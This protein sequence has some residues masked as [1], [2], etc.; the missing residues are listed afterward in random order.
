MKNALALGTFDGIHKGHMCVLNKALNSGRPP[1][2]VI[3]PRP[4]KSFFDSS[5]RCVILPDEK[6]ERL[7]KLGFKE[8]C[9]LDFMSVK[10]MAPTEFLDMLKTQFSCSLISCGFNYRFGKDAA[11]DVDFLKDYCNKNS[12]ELC[13][14]EPF[15]Q[16][17]EILSSTNIRMKLENGNIEFVNSV[18]K[19]PFGFSGKIIDGD[20]RGRTIGFPTINQVYPEILTDVKHGVYKSRVTVNGAEYI[21][22]TNIG[23][24]PTF[25]NGFVSAETH[26]LGFSG[27]VYGKTAD[28]RLEKFIRSE[29]KFSGMEELKN[30]IKNDISKI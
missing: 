23:V 18:I 26:I 1:L 16:N 27:D 2:A 7:K 3:F 14:S 19:F 10:D 24:R 5:V 30:A 20:K 21:G 22:I 29:K 15:S 11:G 4:P 8:V 17:G 12:I 6:E 9:S 13:I 25:A 28:I